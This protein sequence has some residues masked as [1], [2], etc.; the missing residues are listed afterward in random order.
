MAFTEQ[1]IVYI[2]DF[3]DVFYSIV[4]N[5]K[6]V[7]LQTIFRAMD[8]L[9]KSI[10]NLGKVLAEFL[11]KTNTST[12]ERSSMLNA[13]KM[14]IFAKISL[15]KKVDKDVMV[16]DGKKHKKNSQEDIDQLKW[17]E[18]RSSALLQL[19]NVIQLPLGNLWDPPV[20]EEAFVNLCGDFAYRTIEH[21]TIKGQNIVDTCFQILGTLLKSYNHSIVFPVRIFELMKSSEMSSVAIAHGVVILHD[22]HG[23][24]TILKVMID[25]ILNGLDND[26]S[27]GTV[28]KNISAFFTELGNTAPTLVMPFIREIASDVL[29]LESYQLRICIL[30]LMSEILISELNGE[31]LTQDEKDMR[32]EYL[33]HIFAHM[34][35]VNAHVRSKSIGLW[36]Q[37]KKDDTVP[38]IWLSPVLKQAVGR[39]EDKSS[40][41]RKNSIQ[42]IKSFLERN[43]YAAKL[44]LK[45]LKERY[46]E[47]VKELS[48]LRNKMNEEAE[49]IDEVN[50]KWEETI[51]EM[52]PH[53]IKILKRESIEDER[54]RPE[55][56]ENLFEKFQKMIE[57]K[58][59]K[60]LLLLVR[61]AEELNG[62]WG[63][64]SAMDELTSQIYI[65]MLLKS[66]YLLQ[67]SCKNYEE[68]YKKVENAV[69]FLEDSLEFS[70]IVVSAVPKLKELLM[71]K[72]ESDVAEAIDFFTS[73]FMFGIKNTESGMRQLLYL[74]WS[75][76]KDKRGPVRDAYKQVLFTTDLQ[77]RAH[78]VK[79]TFNLMRFIENLTFSQFVAFEELAKEFVESEDIDNQMIQVMFEIYTKK[80]D[81]VTNNDSRLALKLLVIC[82]N[83]KPLIARANVDLI[84]NLCFSKDGDELK[85]SRIFTLTLEFL[86]NI[87][88]DKEDE[89]HSRLDGDNKKVV[90]VLEMFRKYFLNDTSE[91]F[92]EV[93]TK[94]FQYIYKMCDLPNVISQDL[95][96]GLWEELTKISQ[97]LEGAEVPDDENPISQA[98]ILSQ[99]NPID[100]L[101]TMLA[102]PVKLA[103]RFI[104]MIGYVA[105][106]ELIYLDVDVFSN[107]KY[108]QEVT[109]LK[110]NKKKNPRLSGARPSTMNMSSASAV[111]RK[112]MMPHPEDDE[113]EEDVVGQPNDDVF[114]EQI[115]LICEKEMLFQK[116]SIF[117]RFIPMITDILRQPNKYNH[118]LLQRSG[119]LALIH[120]MSVSSQFCDANMQFL[121]NVFQRSKDID[122]KCNVIIGMSD[123]TFRFPN[124]IEPWSGQLYSTLYEEN[125]DLRLTSVRILAHLISHEMILVKVS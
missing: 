62:N 113:N 70:K 41:V 111:K 45:E 102:L 31:E 24:T 81:N 96:K 103:A 8:L 44:S 86:M 116:D 4:D 115:N 77:G 37:M 59:F 118:P 9:Y 17:E 125:R 30:Q 16:S 65:A 91:C 28:V 51:V 3:F 69:R 52:K 6:K 39:L 85:D 84:E 42:L 119:L 95:I 108:R 67:S 97:N 72:T 73:A 107:L 89:I 2:F 22:Q 11:Q 112:S 76:S 110:K 120:F 98:V 55:D 12:K 117:R 48:D 36:T 94:T 101:D 15:V 99:Q 27:D 114:A 5:A 83:I 29:N 53:I 104:F 25:Q 87:N 80:L 40:I 10:D 75:V 90:N 88:A 68:D 64:I 46:E 33:D 54:I 93:C 121:M 13:L 56:C 123:L 79:A 57:E 58:E 66:Y 26:T 18:L 38:L 50:Q 21:P 106:K 122:L 82:S 63:E 100:T 109:D 105:M 60:R 47:K 7:Q 71:S 32:D 20:A 19:F 61:K 92:D 74:V 124:V 78:A 34:L 49:K 35:D 43:P 14:M 1:G 23:I